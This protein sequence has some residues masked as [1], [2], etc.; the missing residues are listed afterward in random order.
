MDLLYS[1]A[2][3]VIVAIS[4]S[5]SLRE[6]DG[7][8]TDLDTT[9]DSKDEEDETDVLDE[10][11]GVVGLDGESGNEEE[12]IWDEYGYIEPVFSPDTAE[13]IGLDMY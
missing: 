8:V 13:D 7:L 5:V 11:G 10:D 2:H 12:D 3:T 1:M 9:S 6:S 4:E